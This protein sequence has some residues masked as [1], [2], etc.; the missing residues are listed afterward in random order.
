VT[1][2][3]VQRLAVVCIGSPGKAFA[4]FVINIVLAGWAYALIEDKGPITGPW[5]GIV[6]GTTTGYGDFTPETTAGRGVAA[7]LM[8]SSLVLASIYTGQVVAFIIPNPNEFTDAEQREI[9][10][11]LEHQNE[12]LHLLCDNQGIEYPRQQPHPQQR[13]AVD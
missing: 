7:Y 12:L 13:A 3:R 8:L 9:L 6:T 5:W 4:V 11:T 10:A 2:A 1:P